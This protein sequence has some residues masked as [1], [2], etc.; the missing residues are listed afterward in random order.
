MM[1]K[2]KIVAGVFDKIK[3]KIYELSGTE[4]DGYE[5]LRGT[6]TPEDNK[7]WSVEYELRGAETDSQEEFDYNTG[8]QSKEL[9]GEG[10]GSMSGILSPRERAKQG[11]RAR[12]R[13]NMTTSKKLR[14]NLVFLCTVFATC[15]GAMSSFAEEVI[16]EPMADV[17]A[18][19][20]ASSQ[21]QPGGDREVDCLELFCWE[22]SYL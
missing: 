19:F 11:V 8:V 4:S 2:G 17:K 5:T 9:F 20:T 6:D 21:L 3:D 15:I 14:N 7:R 16:G 12:K 1:D 10:N 18:I 13:M 22:G